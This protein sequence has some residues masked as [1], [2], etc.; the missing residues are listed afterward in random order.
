MEICHGFLEKI[1]EKTGRKMCKDVDFLLD[2]PCFFVLIAQSFRR[3]VING[4]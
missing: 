2:A 3:K 4:T 1:G